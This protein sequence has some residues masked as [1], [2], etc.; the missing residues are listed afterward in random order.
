MPKFNAKAA[1]IAVDDAPTEI[2]VPVDIESDVR[3]L[4]AIIA[5]SY[6]SVDVNPFHNFDHACHVTMSVSKLIKR[7]VRPTDLT[8]TTEQFVENGGENSHSATEMD[9]LASQLHNHT[10]G[11]TSDPLTIFGIVFA[12]LI[13]D[14]DHQGISNPQLCIEDPVLANKYHSKS[15]AEQNS[16][17]TSWEIF[18]LEQFVSL[19]RFIFGIDPCQHHEELRRFRQVIVNVVLATD[20]FDIKI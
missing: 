20:I 17:D 1:A 14:V 16:I 5:A 18:M 13:H 2:V 7:I 12:A 8:S 10:N 11:L 4:V 19:R 3:D 9:R 15:V 6:K